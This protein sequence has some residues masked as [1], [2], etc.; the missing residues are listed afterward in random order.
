MLMTME[1][2]MRSYGIERKGPAV[3]VQLSGRIDNEGGPVFQEALDK[4]FALNPSRISLHLGEVTFINSAGVGKLLLFYKQVRNRNAE[5]NIAGINDE[6]F[7][8]FKAIRLDKL[9]PIEK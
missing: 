6:V 7:T 5:I 1:E 9:I 4:A 8:L 2:P 3:S